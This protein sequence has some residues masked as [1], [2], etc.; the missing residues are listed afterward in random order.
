M[1]I[2]LFCQSMF[3]Y[4][5]ELFTSSL[6]Q[7]PTLKII[8]PFLSG[9]TPSQKTNQ[10]SSTSCSVHLLVTP[11]KIVSLV[12]HASGT[13]SSRDSFP[14]SSSSTSISTTPGL[15]TKYPEDPVP[16]LNPKVTLYP[17]TPHCTQTEFK[18]SQ[19]YRRHDCNL[20]P[21]VPFRL[22]SQPHVNSQVN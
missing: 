8:P 12:V 13:P 4:Q 6:H 15:F 10:T 19:W 14:R 3:H 1:Y 20:G 22:D 21:S 16:L 5:R 9:R 18:I 7:S 2:H 11:C 17:L